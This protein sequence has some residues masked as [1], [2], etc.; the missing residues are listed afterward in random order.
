MLTFSHWARRSSLQRLVSTSGA[1]Q[2]SL[3][4]CLRA[5]QP[6]ARWCSLISRSTTHMQLVLVSSL[7]SADQAR[8]AA[9]SFLSHFCEPRTLATVMLTHLYPAY[10]RGQTYA[11][12]YRHITTA[13]TQFGTCERHQQDAHVTCSIRERCGLMN[14]RKYAGS[15]RTPTGLADQTIYRYTG[16]TS[17]LLLINGPLGYRTCTCLECESDCNKPTANPSTDVFLSHRDQSPG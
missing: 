10:L 3:S 4:P 17:L 9:V 7:S 1:S 13:T 16:L 14:Y 8:W 5:Y 2:P 11:P 15:V 12:Q 6:L